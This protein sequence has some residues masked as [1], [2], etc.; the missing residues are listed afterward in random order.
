MSGVF[1][2]V[3]RPPLAAALAARGVP[4]WRAGP[5]DAVVAPAES[6]RTVA[7]G[8]PAFV[9]TRDEAEAAAA[10]D[11]GAHDA[12]PHST[13]DILIAARLA[14]W[15]QRRPDILRIGALT[16]DPVARRAARS[17]D[18]LGLLPREFALLLHLARH[19]GRVVPQAELLD[20]IWGL[21]FDPGTNVVQVHISRLRARLD[22]GFAAPMLITHRRKG[23]CL[24]A[25]AD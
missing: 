1:L 19:T 18:E 8:A 10:I 9:L 17:G 15:L 14:A 7:Q 4:L 3:D 13:A 12:A 24:V 20:R 16:I 2:G 23:Y 11:S 21:G 5:P 22:R 6:W 25:A